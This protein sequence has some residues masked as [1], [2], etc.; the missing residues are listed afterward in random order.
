MKLYGAMHVKVYARVVQLLSFGPRIVFPLGPRAK[1][2]LW[3]Y[4]FKLIAN[5]GAG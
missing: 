4:L 3:K 2:T 5:L 1:K